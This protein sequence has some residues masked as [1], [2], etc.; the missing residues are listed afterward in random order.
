M[1]ERKVIITYGES[2]IQGQYWQYWHNYQLR[3]GLGSLGEE[4][5]GVIL[6]GIVKDIR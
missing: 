2:V 4:G 1:E 5:E 6:L 3:L